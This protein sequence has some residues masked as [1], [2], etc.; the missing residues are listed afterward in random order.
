MERGWERGGG[1]V[2]CWSAEEHKCAQAVVG[3]EGRLRRSGGT[4]EGWWE[5]GKLRRGGGRRGS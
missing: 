5:K 1:G 2:E 3:G 4:E